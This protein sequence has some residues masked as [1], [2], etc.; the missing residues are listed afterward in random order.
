MDY[1]EMLEN[2]KKNIGPYC[3]ACPICNGVACKN[4]IPG[5]G[6]KGSGD[7]AIRNYKAWQE[8]RL[9]Q[10]PISDVTST[11]T[12]FDF[13]GYKLSSPIV[14]GP[15][16]A[17][18]SHYGDKYSDLEYNNILLKGCKEAGILGFTG[19]GKV[20]SVLESA[21]KAIEQLDGVGIPT[22]KPWDLDTV[23][24]KIE[25]VKKSHPKAIAMDIDAAGLPF[26]KNQNPPAGVKTVE[27]LNKIVNKCDVPFIVKGV[28]SLNGAK[29]A[30]EAGAKGIVISNHGG[31]VLDSSLSTLSALEEIA[32]QMK[33]KLMLIVDGGIR[34]GADIFKALAL[35][36]DLVLI[37]RPY[38]V[39]LYGGEIEGVKLLTNKLTEELK[40]A[41]MLCG[42][43]NLFEIS[44]DMIKKEI[45]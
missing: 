44:K 21:A 34:S 7:N 29:K 5:P 3:K 6:A 8:Y 12:S 32:P 42:A 13:F 22:I 39:S 35:G 9:I 27:Q 20:A 33:G 43:H 37:A 25:L 11:D 15:V 36:A 10:D 4:Q 41:M 19:D 18:K 23:Y 30:L 16:G 38:V 1:K 26:L 45:I 24:N 17:V 28:M 2:A 31:R 40:D 14:A